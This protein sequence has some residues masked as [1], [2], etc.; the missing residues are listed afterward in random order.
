MLQ[1]FPD[2]FDLPIGSYHI[3][4]RCQ[5]DPTHIVTY[6]SNPIEITPYEDDPCNCEF[7]CLAGSALGVCGTNE[8]ISYVSMNTFENGSPCE[9][10]SG[11]GYT[12]YSGY[13]TTIETGRSYTLF[14]IN[15]EPLPLSKCKA[16]I[17]WNGNG[18]FYDMGEEIVLAGTGLNNTQNWTATVLVPETAHLGSTRMRVRVTNSDEPMPCGVTAVGETEDYCIAVERSFGRLTILGH[19]SQSA[20]QVGLYNQGIFMN[21]GRLIMQDNLTTGNF[22][23][24]NTAT[25]VNG[26]SAEIVID[27][28][29]FVRIENQA[30]GVIQNSGDMKLEQD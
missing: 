13:G 21:Y 7:Y 9:A 2:F 15:G 19:T 23:L 3:K 1:P 20:G 22:G 29:Y 24:W 25:I 11:I 17:D 27:S 14:V 10:S 18:S 26:R 6:H 28:S 8:F 16:W 30:G 4:A 12:D 5:A